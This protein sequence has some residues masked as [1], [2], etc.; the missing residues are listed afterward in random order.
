[1]DGRSSH[2]VPYGVAT[3]SGTD[4]IPDAP[5]F[6][7][8]QD[9]ERRSQADQE[10]I[11]GIVVFA[12][13]QLFCN[14]LVTAI[15]ARITV[16]ETGTN[17]E[18]AEQALERHQPRLSLFIVAPPFPNVA[19]Q[20]MCKKLIERYPSTNALLIF[21]RWQLDDLILAYKH[22]ARGLFDMT[23][24]IETLIGSLERLAYGEIVVQPEILGELMRQRTDDDAKHD[25]DQA[26]SPMQTRMLSLLADGYS[27]KEIAQVMQVTTAA[28][29][30]SIE[31]A[32]QRLGAKHRSQAVARALRLG[33]IV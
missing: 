8:P 31:R 17:Y 4:T 2:G 22:G 19:F 15:E 1:M 18:E 26:L 5:R 28:V 12:P 27:T 23:I 16:L 10:A 24:S 21:Q 14:L 13:G 29:N 32:A 7:V 3:L 33:I 11:N 30:H 6:Q 25:E 9:A 20:D